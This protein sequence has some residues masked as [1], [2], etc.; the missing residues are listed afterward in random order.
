[1]GSMSN[2]LVIGGAGYIGSHV[3]KALVEN[4]QPPIVLD[5]LSGGSAKCLPKSAPFY[6]GDMADTELL[7]HLFQKYQ[8]DTVM[9]L[10][11]L[12]AVEESVIE[13]Q[14]YYQTNVLKTTELID[15]LIESEIPDFI[16]SSS[17][18]VYGSPESL[19]MTES[20]PFSPQSPYGKNKLVIE[21]LL[22]DYARAHPHFDY[23]SLRYFNASGA[24]SDSAIGE[25]H[26]PETHLIPL[27]F[28]ALSHP[29]NP[30]I[31][32]GVDYPTPD[33][34]C[35]RDYVHV[36]DI[37]QA[38]LKAADYLKK[39]H[40][41]QAFN[42]GNGEGVSVKEMIQYIEKMTGLKVPVQHGERRMGDPAKLIGSNALAKETLGW[43]PEHSKIEI[44]L[45]TAWKWHLKC[46]QK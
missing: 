32:R 23:V 18:A 28:Q 29:E 20:H 19:P 2:T 39:G 25:C 45:E 3:A 24:A 27:I 15:C 38:H 7:K 26:D 35:I 4:G 12:I 40:K 13:P 42:L 6:K 36:S 33:G 44:I 21:H 5:N 31:I 17:C 43:F 37:A 14:K 1:M 41:S 10:A 16:F 30:I 46:H 8:I 22:S 34:T 9:N 11:G